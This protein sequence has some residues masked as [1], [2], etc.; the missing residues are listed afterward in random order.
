MADATTTTTTTTTLTAP[1][2]LSEFAQRKRPA[3]AGAD[4]VRPKEARTH[5]GSA[6]SADGVHTQ[7]VQHVNLRELIEMMMSVTSLA[8]SFV[9]SH[10]DQLAPPVQSAAATAPSRLGHLKTEQ[11]E[12]EDEPEL[13][14]RADSLGEEPPRR[15]EAREAQRGRDVDQRDDVT[16]FLLSLAPAM[17]RLPAEKQSWLRTRMQQ[18]VHEA[19]FGPTSFQ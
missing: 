3:S 17:R 13:L 2:S 7:Q 9:S 4:T 18:L 15:T 5:L 1:S 6:G 10:S 16:L 12:A 19:E 14:D 11:Q 8:A